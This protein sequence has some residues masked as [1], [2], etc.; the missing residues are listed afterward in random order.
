MAR[1]FIKTHLPVY[2][3]PGSSQNPMGGLM[4]RNTK[5][6]LCRGNFISPN[7]YCTPTAK[8]IRTGHSQCLQNNPTT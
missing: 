2:N 3:T 6:H 5:R 4:S 1:V 7:Q 8:H